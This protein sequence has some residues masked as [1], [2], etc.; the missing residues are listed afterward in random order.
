MYD[1]T[2]RDLQPDVERAYIALCVFGEQEHQFAAATPEDVVSVVLQGAQPLGSI[3]GLRMHVIRDGIIEVQLR[4]KL[5]AP[6][7]R[8]IRANLEVDVD[9]SARIPTRIDRDELGSSTGVCRLIAA[10]ELFPSG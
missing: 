8:R 10:Q 4:R 3:G 2:S 9:G 7:A 1:V 6:L 5:K